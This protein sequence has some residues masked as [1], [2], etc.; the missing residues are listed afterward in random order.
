MLHLPPACQYFNGQTMF[1]AIDIDQLQLRHVAWLAVG[2]AI[3]QQAQLMAGLQA[4]LE[5]D[6]N[7]EGAIVGA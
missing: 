3:K 6:A 5:V 2:L 7:A 4:R 1:T